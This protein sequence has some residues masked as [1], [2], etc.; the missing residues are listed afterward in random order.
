MSS[1]EAAVDYLCGAAARRIWTP[2]RFHRTRAMAEHTIEVLGEFVGLSRLSM[3]PDARIA[4]LEDLL[5]SA[6][7]RIQEDDPLHARIDHALNLIP[8]GP[9]PPPGGPNQARAEP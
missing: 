9:K 6:Q 5:L 4:T 8:P 3:E 1:R 7:E 2:F